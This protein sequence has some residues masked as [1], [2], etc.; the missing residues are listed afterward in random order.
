MRYSFHTEAKIE[1]SFAVDY[2]ENRKLL[3]GRQFA[4]EVSL[5][6]QRIVAYPTMWPFI[7]P[8]VRRC[9]LRRFP[10]GIIYHIDE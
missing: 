6:I 10:F 4:T 1:L 5:T 2:Y 7:G 9:L 8:G 3:L